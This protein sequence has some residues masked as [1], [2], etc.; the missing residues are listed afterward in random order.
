[1]C[2]AFLASSSD[3]GLSVALGRTAA[4]KTLQTTSTPIYS[5]GCKCSWGCPHRIL[6]HLLPHQLLDYQ[7]KYH[8]SRPR[9]A[10][11]TFPQRSV[12]LGGDTSQRLCGRCGRAVQPRTSF[13]SNAGGLQSRSSQRSWP[14]AAT[15]PCTSG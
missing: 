7:H 11:S 4:E 15:H 13:V 8:I 9:H 14:K 5:G 6:H 10:I 3:A 12:T 2:A 1:M